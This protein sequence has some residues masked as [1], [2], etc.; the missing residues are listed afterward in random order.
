MVFRLSVDTTGLGSSSVRSWLVR[1]DD[2]TSL[3]EL[4]E[5][6]GADAASIAGSSAG[7]T[8]GESG[9]RTGS[10]VPGWTAAPLEPG[11]RR[12]EII[13][14]PFAGETFAPPL[15]VPITI[16]SSAASGLC[17]ADPFVAPHHATLMLDGAQ[18]VAAPL[19]AS[20]HPDAPD[21]PVL[22]NGA[23]ITE[24]TRLVPADIVQI[25]SVLFR[26]GVEPASDADLSRDDVGTL[27]FNRPSRILPTRQPPLVQ[28]PGDRPDE[29]DK[30]PLPWLSAVI[31]VILGVTMAVLFARPVMLMMA[32]ASPVM[33]V[34]TFLT[35]RSRAKKKGERTIDQWLTEISD[36][37]DRIATLVKEQRLDAWY[38]SP[39][40]VLLRDIA[41]RPLSRLW[42]R[43][44]TDADALQV[45]VGVSEVELAARFEGGPQK[46]RGAPQRV[47]VAPAPVV[48]NLAA[49]VMG[50]AGPEDVTR[51]TARAMLTS[52]ATLRSPR[53]LTVVVL[54]DERDGV[55]WEWV[56]WLPHAQAGASV[57]ALVGNTDETRRERLREVSALLAARSRSASERGMNEFESDV[58]VVVDGARRYRTLTGMVP[59]LQGGGRQGVHIIALDTDRS[60]LPEEAATTLVVDT[61]DRSLARFESGAAYYGNVLLDGMSVSAAESIARSLCSIKHVSGVG[62]EALLP[63]SVRY[64][65]LLHVDLDDPHKL[66]ER[67]MQSPRSTYVVVGAGLDGQFAL[68]VAADG[69]HALVAGTTGSGKSEFLQTL[70]ISLAMANRPDALNFVLIDYKGASAFA[71]CARLPHTVGMVTNLDARETERA[72]VSLDAELK[73]RERVLQSE[74]LRAKDV[75]AA[76]A[77]NPDAAARLG[78]ARLMIV[79]DEFAEL[80]TEHPDFIAG[81]V[82]IARVGRSLGVHLVLATQ[83]PS[84]IVTP[85]MQSN[86]NLRVA[87]RVTDRADSTDVLGSVDASLISVATPG[88]GFVRAGN[89][90]AP[91]PFQTARVAGVRAGV[92][93]TRKTLPPR[94]P[95][96]WS[97]LGMAPRFPAS[98]STQAIRADHDD[99]DLRALVQLVTNAAKLLGIA[100]NASPWVV[101]LPDNLPLERVT[102]DELGE[103][104]I[105]LGLEDVPDEQTQR[106]LTWDLATGG[107]LLFLGGALSGRTSALRTV[108]AQTIEQFSPVDLHLYVLDYGNGAFLPFAAAPHVGAVVTALEPDRL[109]R[110]MDRLTEELSSRQQV[111][112]EAGVASI[113]EQRRVAAPG[114]AL[115]YV[116]IAI[117][118]WERVLA[119]QSADDALAFRAQ[120]M[121]ALREGPSVGIRVVVTGDRGIPGD[122][123]AGFIDQQFALP[124]RDVNDYRGA[125]V[126]IREL[127]VH[128]PSGRAL[129]GPT[130]REVQL[131]V[132]GRD[133]DGEA[134]A[135]T[136]KGIV[137]EIVERWGSD[138]VVESGPR[139]FRVDPL[140]RHY[141]LSTAHVLPLAPGGPGDGPV[142]GVGG[143][144]L[145]R[146]T[147]EWPGSGGFVILGGRG[148][149]KSTA[150]ATIVQQLAATSTPLVVVATRPSILTEAATE[151]RVPILDRADMLSDA[152]DRVFAPFESHPVTVVVDDAELIRDSFLEQSLTAKKASLVFIVAAA[153]EAAPSMFGGP[154]VEAKKARQG[155][156]LAPTGALQANT[157][158]GEKIPKFMLGKSSKGGG[159]VFRLGEFVQVQVPQAGR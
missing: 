76:W 62:D 81:L 15:G 106:P 127:P 61:V 123:I 79:I 141:P 86:I 53:D 52:L 46:D 70:I 115:P 132:L 112:S 148:S 98:Q 135:A 6:V 23:R 41:T 144:E 147:I 126:L 50:I 1:A 150:L 137:A 30:T 100:K 131:A 152:V 47:G 121:R 58:V 89:A 21:S 7:R 136:L 88:K 151:L 8:I 85:E 155:M 114:S 5:S 153:T 116:V 82:R 75:D 124:M 140:P 51:S 101:P 43:R 93:R 56:Q 65:D 159:A 13:G 10:I 49:G 2:E 134:Q 40:A 48:A 139:P 133:A 138:P 67:W 128:L 142:I 143:D 45:R 125:G 69:P 146:Y 95:I 25:G 87:L 4:A 22:V 157:V 110:L 99:T 94:A 102:A 154:L 17:I 71:D 55:D 109:P 16:G 26:I 35:N 27:G 108:L 92:H 74:E 156:I 31:P 28:L 104:E 72:L 103:T 29:Q 80:K 129:F 97:T 64:V 158:F 119:T 14:G 33:V 113:T 66:A 60:R 12:L 3:A 96:E 37:R 145:S 42:E 39:D 149:G 63:T 118:G 117:D 120:I 36:T 20:I 84:G 18:D 57:V 59:L 19:T 91:I 78:L 24:A 9:L 122:K 105:V 130:G 77:K 32:A 44:K 90:S 111:L 73:R 107:H 11:T 54:C 83:R 34:G 38:R 68:D